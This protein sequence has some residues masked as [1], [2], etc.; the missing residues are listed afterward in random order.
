M[1]QKTLKTNQIKN[2]RIKSYEA[3][4]ALDDEIAMTLTCDVGEVHFCGLLYL[5]G[6]DAPYTDSII[7]HPDFNQFTDSLLTSRIVS[8]DKDDNVYRFNLK[9]DDFSNW[10][11]QVKTGEGGGV[12]GEIF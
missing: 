10:S 6:S 11:F 7:D 2:W 12:D 8:V 9:N 4:G 1:R 5:T 3:E